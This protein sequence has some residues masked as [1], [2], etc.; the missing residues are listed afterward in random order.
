MRE[1]GPSCTILE[2][3]WVT[4]RSGDTTEALNA[5]EPLSRVNG[6]ES[7]SKKW[8]TPSWAILLERFYAQMRLPL[9]RIEQVKENE[10]PEPYHRLLVHSSD[11]TP[12]LEG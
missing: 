6:A 10:V 5:P 4:P 2:Q 3:P 8:H 1:V 12:T 11:M 7:R 9:P